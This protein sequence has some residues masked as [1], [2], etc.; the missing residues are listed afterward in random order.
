MLVRLGE[1]F[2]YRDM[3]HAIFDNQDLMN[4]DCLWRQHFISMESAAYLAAENLREYQTNSNN[5]SIDS[6]LHTNAWYHR[7]F[8][9][10]SIKVKSEGY[11]LL[12]LHT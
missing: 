12:Y 7:D 11:D 3:D 8:Q 2:Q 9:Y 5:N 6:R 1:K 10:M 4:T